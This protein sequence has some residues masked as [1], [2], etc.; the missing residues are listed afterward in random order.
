MLTGV[1]DG[2]TDNVLKE[3]LQDATSLL[4]DETRDAL[5]TTTTSKTTN[6]RLGDALNVV[7]KNL[8]VTL[9]TTGIEER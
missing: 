1:S 9:C 8:A 2:V 6:G 3:D 7:T 4:V 5:D